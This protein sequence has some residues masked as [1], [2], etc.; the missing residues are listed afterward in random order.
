M[1]LSWISE[2]VRRCFV[3]S[4]Y[5]QIYIEYIWLC[6]VYS[7][8]HDV[9]NFSD[10]A[11][12]LCGVTLWFDLSSSG[13]A[14]SVL[15]L[16]FLSWIHRN[17]L[18]C[19]GDR[20]PS[21][22]S[23]RYAYIHLFVHLYL[24]RMYFRLFCVFFQFRS[25]AC[26]EYGSCN[27]IPTQA[28]GATTMN[29]YTTGGSLINSIPFTIYAQ[30][31]QWRNFLV[32]YAKNTYVCSF[33]V[34]LWLSGVSCW[35]VIDDL[36]RYQ[37]QYSP[38]DLCVPSVVCPLSLCVLTCARTNR[39]MVQLDAGSDIPS[40]SLRVFAANLFLAAQPMS[41]S[42][43]CSLWSILLFLFLV[44]HLIFV[45]ACD[46][47]AAFQVDGA[48]A[49][50]ANPLPLLATVCVAVAVVVVLVVAVVVFVVVVFR[51]TCRIFSNLSI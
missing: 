8:Q 6:C 18:P 30:P 12:C 40:G 28:A 17:G 11:G 51:L 3:L 45:R 16:Q 44:S 37:S 1:L 38:S 34:S 50:G 19:R 15:L 9:H 5:L 20:V 27:E 46:L 35:F 41:V 29:L 42:K 39:V 10:G 36:C 21:H 25:L 48:T 22:D 32:V 33:A 4:L 23:Q 43:R 13:T 31:N 14:K 24:F 7:L 47:C 49:T 26:S 2:A